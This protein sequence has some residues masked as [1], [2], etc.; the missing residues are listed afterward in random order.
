MEQWKTLG[1]YIPSLT[2]RL[3]TANYRGRNPPST[4]AT[5]VCPTFFTPNTYRP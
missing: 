2:L 5:G 4:S 3:F 1:I